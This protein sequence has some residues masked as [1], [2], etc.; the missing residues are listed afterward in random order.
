ME[1][2]EAKNGKS[3]RIIPL[4]RDDEYYALCRAVI[5]IPPEAFRLGVF[6]VR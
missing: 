6:L 5:H 4:S 1:Q 2:G 3:R